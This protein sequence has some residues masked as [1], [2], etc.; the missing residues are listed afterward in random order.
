MGVQVELGVGDGGFGVKVSVGK[1]VNVAVGIGVSVGKKAGVSVKTGISV[2]K[3]VGVAMGAEVVVVQPIN[4]ESK[5][6][7]SGAACAFI[8]VLLQERY[9]KRITKSRSHC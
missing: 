4:N 2:G 9:L 8:D 6:K 1:T 7:K 3:E 5:L